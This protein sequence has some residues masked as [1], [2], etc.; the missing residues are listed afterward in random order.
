M[1][2]PAAASTTPTSTS[3]GGK[4]RPP[5][6][7]CLQHP[8]QQ[9]Q[10]LQHQRHSAPTPST[11]SS[12]S[13]S[14]RTLNTTLT[15]LLLPLA[16]LVT[17]TPP[18]P[19]SAN[20]VWLSGNPLG[21]SITFV[22]AYLKGADQTSKPS[23]EAYTIRG[24]I[25]YPDCM[26]YVRGKVPPQEV[27]LIVWNAELSGIP[28]CYIKKYDR[29]DTATI[30]WGGDM[31][32]VL[33]GR[34]FNDS[35]YGPWYLNMTLNECADTCQN[36]G[37]RCTAAMYFPNGSCIMKGFNYPTSYPNRYITF[38]WWQWVDRVFDGTIPPKDL[39]PNATTASTTTAAAAPTT[40]TSAPAAPSPTPS[41]GAGDDAVAAVARS[42]VLIGGLVGG[43][44]VA[45]VA[46]VAAVVVVL[47]LRKRRT[48]ARRSDVAAAGSSAGGGTAGFLSSRGGG[49]GG[50]GGGDGGGDRRGRGD[51]GSDDGDG[52]SAATAFTRTA[53]AAGGSV[54]AVAQAIPEWPQSLR[55]TLATAE[56]PVQE[57]YQLS[58]HHGGVAVD[59]GGSSSSQAG[60]DAR[61]GL[62]FRDGF[63]VPCHSVPAAV[64]TSA[65]GSSQVGSSQ[66]QAP[67][68]T[69]TEP[70]SVLWVAP[71]DGGSVSDRGN[72]SSK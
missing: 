61:P 35:S 33:P 17:I 22:N 38:P 23:N 7:L 52:E 68:R 51:R 15:A 31:G 66:L 37:D 50:G 48:G 53:G 11:F 16:A 1:A 41:G 32:C 65:Y 56:P 45:G 21:Y 71:I 70:G 69:E 20:K 28:G 72:P 39:S 30:V 43:A 58:Y 59:H 36:D 34:Y 49:G 60:S 55:Q 47:V 57:G 62:T 54:F 26:Y 27:D 2:A 10:Q 29:M 40:S 9:L 25:S 12:S 8:Q 67:S 18:H 64:E 24:N 6:P 3:A 63:A 46:A 13:N 4:R 19:A 42:S 5:N 44:I 14:S